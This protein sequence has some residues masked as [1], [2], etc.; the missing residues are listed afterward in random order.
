MLSSARLAWECHN[1]ENIVE[2]N[3]VDVGECVKDENDLKTLGQMALDDA[4]QADPTKVLA[5]ALQIL[6]DCGYN[7]ETRRNAL[8]VAR[9]IK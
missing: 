3:D 1:K 4:K 2:T 5:T 7:G 6:R 8:C 9:A